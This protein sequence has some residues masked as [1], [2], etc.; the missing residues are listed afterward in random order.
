IGSYQRSFA[1]IHLG[2]LGGRLIGQLIFKKGFPAED[3]PP[4]PP[5][6]PFTIGLCEEDRLIVL[7]GPLK[8]GRA[9]VIRKADGSIGWLR[10]GR[11]YKK[12]D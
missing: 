3:S 6:P 8:S 7:D 9:E 10:F 1:D 4:P 2:M 12:L 5:P 11:I